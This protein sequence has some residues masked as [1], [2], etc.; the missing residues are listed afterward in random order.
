MLNDTTLFHL[1]STQPGSQ[2][3]FSKCSQPR[4]ESSPA[5]VSGEGCGARVSSLPRRSLLIDPGTEA[6][7]AQLE[8]VSERRVPADGQVCPERTRL[9][10]HPHTITNIRMI[11][12]DFSLTCTV[13]IESTG[14]DSLGSRMLALTNHLGRHLH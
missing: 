8:A 2:G 9:L 11:S 1:V 7:R 6:S 12:S 14:F 10:F 3:L 4:Q 5:L 13:S